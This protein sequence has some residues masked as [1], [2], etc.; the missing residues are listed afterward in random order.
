[1]TKTDL[2]NDVAYEMAP[3]LTE[4]QIDRLKITML[5]KLKNFEVTEMSWLPAVQNHDNEWLLKRYMVDSL[6]V[7]NHES[8]IKQYIGAMKVFFRES[9]KNYQEVLGQD[10]TDYLALKQYRDHISQNYKS[11]LYRYF[12]SFFGWAYRKHHIGQDI[13]LDVDRVKM[14]QKKKERLTDEDVEDIRE[15]LQ[16]P[17][18]KALF[19]LMLSTGMRVSEIVHLNIG[20]IDLQRKRVTIWGQ[21]SSKYRTG[22]LNPKAVKALQ[23]YI[24]SRAGDEPLFYSE[25]GHR[26]L[27]KEWIQKMAKDIAVRGGITRVKVTVHVYRKT[28]ASVLYRKTQDVLLVSKLLGHSKTDLTVQYYLIDDIDDMQY[29]Y[30]AV[31]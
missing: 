9:G 10:I 24:G 27:S 4:H 16:N 19:E 29:R 22:M 26:R 6:A 1:M 30:S 12:S 18:E 14:M 5:V 28:F 7:G 31:Q 15:V 8:T 20:D 13:M 23:S 2:I 25:R 3:E 17:R 11:T 21:K